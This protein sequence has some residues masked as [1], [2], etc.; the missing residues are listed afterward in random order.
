MLAPAIDPY[1]KQS[2]EFCEVLEIN[3]RYKYVKG[4]LENRVMF[5]NFFD[6]DGDINIGERVISRGG[7][8]GKLI[9]KESDGSVTIQLF[10]WGTKVKFKSASAARM[11]H[12]APILDVYGREERSDMVPRHIKETID[13]CFR[14]HV[15]ISPNK[16]DIMKRRHK[17][18]PVQ[19]LK[20]QA[21][22]CYETFDELW[23]KFKTELVDLGEKFFNRA[24]GMATGVAPIIF[25]ACS[26]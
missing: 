5:D 10:P 3:R 4:H 26:S 15:H 1:K 24:R 7:D 16:R 22:H 14:R 23:S 20:K 12:R 11:R 25:S 18:Y 2:R 17:L 9:A 19:Q 21:M 8:D 13:S 6:L